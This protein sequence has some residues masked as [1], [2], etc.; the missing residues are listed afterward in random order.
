MQTAALAKNPWA[1]IDRSALPRHLAV[2][3]DGNRRWA[4]MRSLPG[5]SGHRAGRDTLRNLV[6]F[7]RELGI[8]HLTAFA[9]STENWNRSEEEVSFLWAL[10]KD[11][12]EREVQDLHRNNVKMRFIGEIHELSSDFRRSIAEAEALTGGNTGLTFNIALNYGGRREIVAAARRAAAAVQEGR[13]SPEL[14]TEEVFGRF[15]YT[16]EQPDP[17]LLI[18]TSG[19]FRISNYLLWQLAYTEIYVTNT[20]WPDFG[21][22]DL[23]QALLSYQ[24]RDRRF[25]ARPR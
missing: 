3:M 1:G 7:C 21:Q 25:G 17:D 6:R 8:S 15:L 16:G 9:F 11:T 12:L 22:E 2:I 13:L 23:R 14:L 18:R 19:E 20:F 10:F 24:K 4:L 5:K